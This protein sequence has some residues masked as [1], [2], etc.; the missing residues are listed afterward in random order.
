MYIRKVDVKLTERDISRMVETVCKEV[1]STQKA[2]DIANIFSELL[3]NSPEGSSLFIQIMLGNGLPKVACEGDVVRCNWDRL[4]IGLTDTDEI[5]KKLKE[6]NL[7]N[8][9]NEVTCKI[10]S[11]KGYTAYFPYTVEFK[12]GDDL[13]ASA[14]MG[15]EDLSW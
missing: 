4:K 5:Y 9:R 1:Q 3:L 8:S 2:N 10:K 6:S 12:Y 11:F 15:F 13:Y 14:S 7:I